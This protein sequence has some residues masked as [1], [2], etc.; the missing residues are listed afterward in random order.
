MIL[1]LDLGT[2]HVGLVVLAPTLPVR[3]LG[4]K[5]L[6]VDAADLA[7]IERAEAWILGTLDLAIAECK[8]KGLP[9]PRVVIEWGRFWI[10]AAETSQKTA[11]KGSAMGEAR[12]PMICMRHTVEKRCKALGV[13]STR[14]TVNTWRARI[15]CGKARDD[16]GVMVAL[17]KHTPLD[18]LPSEHARDAA[19]AA[20]GVLLGEQEE[21]ER[22]SNPR[23]RARKPGGGKRLPSPRALAK[24]AQDAA[25][26]ALVEAAQARVANLPSRALSPHPEARP[27]GCGL[28]GPHRQ[29]CQG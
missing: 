3:V 26:D 21:R 11:A 23:R 4:Y 13:Q 6:E 2:R 27:C 17:A 22:A 18:A 28:R 10:K 9:A 14:I 19:G 7:S 20:V 15:G 16:A 24:R 1:S 12:D 5:P 29:G 8:A 25:L